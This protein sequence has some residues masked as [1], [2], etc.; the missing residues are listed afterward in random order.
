MNEGD[1]PGRKP[2]AFGTG[3]PN[4]HTSDL[5]AW[6]TSQIEVANRSRTAI[7]QRQRAEREQARKRKARRQQQKKDKKKKKKSRKDSSSDSSSSE[8]ASS[9]ISGFNAE[10]ADPHKFRRVARQKPGCLFGSIIAIHRNA[11]GQKGFD[12]D[13]GPRGPV[14]HNWMDKCFRHDH[15]RSKIGERN[16]DELQML[17]IA[18]DEIINGRVLEGLDVLTSRLRC[19]AFQVETGK[20]EVSEEFLCYAREETSLVSNQLVSAAVELHKEG[21]KRQKMLASVGRRDR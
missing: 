5:V 13:I 18:L 3:T 4:F 20:K 7:L 19:L 6:L 8:S 14:F 17:I 11:L 15:P 12:A 1:L 16:W 10:V 2:G 21:Q 9:S